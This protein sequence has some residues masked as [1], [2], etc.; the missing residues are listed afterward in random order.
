[1]PSTRPRYFRTVRCGRVAHIDP[2]HNDSAPAFR[3]GFSSSTRSWSRII[4]A[5]P[6]PPLPRDWDPPWGPLRLA[7]PYGRAERRLIPRHEIL[8]VGKI[9]LPKGPSVDCTVRNFSPAGA[10]L[11]LKN[12]LNLPVKFDLHL[13]T[14]LGIASSCGDDLTGWV[15]DSDPGLEPP[16]TR[17]IPIG[18]RLRRW[19]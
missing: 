17:R 2:R 6:S 18:V 15:C 5:L 7:T 4:L 14:S 9:T 11:W 1:M 16:P 8:M 3:R 12:A 19:R 13:T 10:A